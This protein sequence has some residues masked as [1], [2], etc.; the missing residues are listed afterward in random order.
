MRNA[1]GEIDNIAIEDISK[2]EYE[3]GKQDPNSK[4]DLVLE[5]LQPGT[6]YIL[7]L[8]FYET[9]IEVRFVTE[10]TCAESNDIT[11]KTGAPTD[12]RII[13]QTHG[14]VYFE[15]IDNSLCA[16]AECDYEL[17]DG[18][19]EAVDNLNLSKLT[20]GHT[21]VYCVRAQSDKG[22]YMPSP[23]D[24]TEGSLD[25]SHSEQNCAPHTIQWEASINGV[26]T[27]EPNAGLLPIEDVIVEYQLLSA[28]YEKLSCEGCSGSL[29]T[30]AGGG[31]FI[32]FNIVHPYIVHPY[33]KSSTHLDE[34]PVKLNFSKTTVGKETITHK[35]LCNDSEFDCTETGLIVF[36]KHLEFNKRV[37]VYDATTIM[38]AGQVFLDNT[39]FPG[40]YGCPIS[41]AEV[42]VFHLTTNGNSEVLSEVRTDGQGH[43]EAPAVIGA[44][45]NKVE[46]VH[47]DHK[48]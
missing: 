26:I 14:K 7:T 25:L 46:I 32:P 6:L 47:H 24:T 39:V 1:Q 2:I 33:S 31:F 27:T 22:P 38:L 48:A 8:R 15:F 42:R 16:G 44:Q 20:V 5:G 37:H 45:V 41:D 3:S 17:I 43:Y 18:K 36:L 10:C 9:F 35:F 30:K 29:V 4:V 12:F 23:Y 34:F 21:Y 13:E 40:S 11:D 28:T 19:E